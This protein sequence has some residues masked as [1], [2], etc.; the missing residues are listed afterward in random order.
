M[1]E[2]EGMEDSGIEAAD[3][4]PDHKGLISLRGRTD[5]TRCRRSPGRILKQKI[6]MISCISTLLP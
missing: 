4:G 2:A 6:H 3:Q 1:S 5:F